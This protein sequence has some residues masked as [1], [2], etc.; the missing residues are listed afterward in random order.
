[1]ILD[2][3]ATSGNPPAADLKH[4]TI[5]A[6]TTGTAPADFHLVAS[7]T[8]LEAN[9]LQVFHFPHVQ[10]A[11]YVELLMNDNYGGTQYIELAEAEI[12]AL[13]M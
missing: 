10:P 6:S 8:C 7:G 4:F 3:A 1:V 2:P 12:V 11:R 9:S 13:P 5:L